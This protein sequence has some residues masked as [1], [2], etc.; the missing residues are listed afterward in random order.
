VAAS[1]WLNDNETNLFEVIHH[2]I[3]ERLVDTTVALDAAEQFGRYF[4]TRGHPEHYRRLCESALDRACAEG[5]ADCP[6]L[7]A[8]GTSGW[9]S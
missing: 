8:I 9:R 1:A 6:A 7:A 5:D 3:D 4:T 2:A